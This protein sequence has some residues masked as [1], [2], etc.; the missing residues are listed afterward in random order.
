MVPTV[1]PSPLPRL[2]LRVCILIASAQLVI[3]S[4]TIV[5]YL[6]LTCNCSSFL[7]AASQSLYVSYSMSLG[8]NPHALIGSRRASIF[9]S[10]SNQYC[11][12]GKLNAAV[13][14]RVPGSPL[15]RQYK[16]SNLARSEERRVGKEC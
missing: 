4:I 11:G 12:P 1:L 13:D 5:L 8:S 7:R 6:Q 10:K 16:W 14:L 9:P 2:N 3:L 15:K